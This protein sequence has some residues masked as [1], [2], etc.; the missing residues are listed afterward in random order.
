MH[1]AYAGTDAPAV[2]VK[3]KYQAVPPYVMRA[4]VGFNTFLMPASPNLTDVLLNRFAAHP[5]NC[6]VYSCSNLTDPLASSALSALLLPVLSGNSLFCGLGVVNLS[7]HLGAYIAAQ[8][9]PT[10]LPSNL[11]RFWFGI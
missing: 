6:S 10:P 9:L 3:V 1:T 7:S 2:P 11:L 5:L 8:F 4:S